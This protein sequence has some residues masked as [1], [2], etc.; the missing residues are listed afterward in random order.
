MSTYLS[1]SWKPSKASEKEAS[2]HQSK[3]KKKNNSPSLSPSNKLWCDEL[4]LGLD[5]F[6]LKRELSVLDFSLL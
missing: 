2:P 5:D 6:F 4:V 3:K 1:L